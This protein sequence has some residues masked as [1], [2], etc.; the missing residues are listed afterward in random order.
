MSAVRT[1]ILSGLLLMGFVSMAEGASIQ[2]GVW[3]RWSWQAAETPETADTTR[4]SAPATPAPAV[5]APPAPADPAPGSIAPSTATP[6]DPP[7]AP[8]GLK[9]VIASYQPATASPAP[10]APAASAYS[11]TA[12]TAQGLASTPTYQYDARIGLGDGPYPQADLLTAGGAQPWYDSPVVTGLYGHVPNAQERADFSN[13]ILNRVEQTYEK[14]GLHMTATVDP[15]APA[16]HTMSV[17]SNTAS[18]SNPNAIGLTSMRGDGFSFIDKFTYA[19]SIDELQWAVAHN[20]AHELMH[21]FGGEHHDTAGQFLDAAVSPWEV[22]VNPNTVFSSDSVAD[23][24]SKD[25][26]Q[27]A[28]AGTL[29]A[30][31]QG[32]ADGQE[33]LAPVPE[34]ATLAVWAVAAAWAVG[35]ARPHR[36][37]A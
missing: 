2:Q 36:K 23:L 19:K 3:W 15:T 35:S 1:L 11:G 28:D 9:E 14:S 16:A 32:V 24:A 21:A 10:P 33:L 6:T 8:F 13:T 26:K 12:S 5:A 17:V 37:A 29:G 30:G 18:T 25:F 20:V 22:L 31:G 34:P 27:R 7:L 4:E